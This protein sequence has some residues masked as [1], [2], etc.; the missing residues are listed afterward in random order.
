[1]NKLEDAGV[2][3]FGLNL[4]IAHETILNIF[5]HRGVEQRAKRPPNKLRVTLK[6]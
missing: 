1:M 2:Q 6:H 5:Y 4:N 3:T